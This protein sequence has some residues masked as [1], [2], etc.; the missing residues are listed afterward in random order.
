MTENYIQRCN[1]RPCSDEKIFYKVVNITI[2]ESREK[3]YHFTR[4]SLH[5]VNSHYNKN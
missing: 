2:V 1:R 3:V 4:Q 5:S